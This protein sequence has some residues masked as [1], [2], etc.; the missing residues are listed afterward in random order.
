MSKLLV[1]KYSEVLHFFL[2]RSKYFFSKDVSIYLVVYILRKL[3]SP[4]F[5]P[6][7][8]EHLAKLLSLTKCNLHIHAQSSGAHPASHPM[9]AGA[10]FPG[11]KRSGHEDDH[12]HPSSSEVKSMWR[13]T[14]NP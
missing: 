8:I 11:V 1:I 3:K 5:T 10:P 12:S 6:T 4:V 9:G 7:H 2:V 13:Y 14:S